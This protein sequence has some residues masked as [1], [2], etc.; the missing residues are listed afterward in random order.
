MYSRIQPLMH[1]VIF[2]CFYG[3]TPIPR[4]AVL[5]KLLL[6]NMESVI[7]CYT[8]VWQSMLYI[9]CYLNFRYMNIMVKILNLRRQRFILVSWRMWRSGWRVGWAQCLVFWPSSSLTGLHR[10]HSQSFF[11]ILIWPWCPREGVPVVRAST[12][13]CPETAIR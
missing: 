6:M 11:S 3:S 7:N 1:N 5:V 8:L 10:L 2:S 9:S 13:D 4:D 12:A